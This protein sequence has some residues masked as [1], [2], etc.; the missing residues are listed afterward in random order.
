[1]ST[2]VSHF[3]HDAPSTAVLAPVKADLPVDHTV[4]LLGM[5]SLHPSRGVSTTALRGDTG[6]GHLGASI[7]HKLM[8]FSNCWQ[9]PAV[10]FEKASSQD[11]RG[12]ICFTEFGV[13]DAFSGSCD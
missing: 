4:L 8:P 6:V 7:S 10:A 2:T 12:A 13:H 1:M 3:D 5:L 9:M 11:A